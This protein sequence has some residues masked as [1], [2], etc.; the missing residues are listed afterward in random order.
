[1]VSKIKTSN[2][3]ITN[4]I[5]GIKDNKHVFLL[6]FMDGCGPCDATKPKW[7]AFEEKHENDDGIVIVDIEQGS[8]DKISDIVG[9]SPGGFPCMRYYHNGKMEEYEKCSGLDNTKLRSLESFDHWMDL[10]TK[11]DDKHTT[12]QGGKRTRRTRTKKYKRGGKWSIKYKNSINCKHPKGFSQKQH[13]K[14][15]RKGWKNK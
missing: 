3:K 6:I 4:F 8:L 14:Y 12:Q 5:D 11:K 10:K 15:G 7:K 13:C 2:E 1:M 9:E